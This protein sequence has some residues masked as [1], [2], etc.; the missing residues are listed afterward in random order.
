MSVVIYNHMKIWCSVDGA[1]CCWL[2]F[3]Q[4]A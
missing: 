1:W 3:A 4:H 2:I